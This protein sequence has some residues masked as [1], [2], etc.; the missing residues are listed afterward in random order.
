MP[1]G[2][3]GGR[4]E[5]VQ[6]SLKELLKLE[7]QR[8]EEQARERAAREAVAARERE[9]AERLRR[10]DVEAQAK[11]DAA[12]REH[13]RRTELEELARREAMQKAIVEQSRLE[14]EVRARADERERE[15]RHEIA[16]EQLRSTSK[17]GQS[18]GALMAASALGGG[19]MAIVGIVIH[20]GVL[21]PAA[22]RRLAGLEQGVAAAE[23]RADQL[24]RQ[25]DEE[26]RRGGERERQLA[27]AR[28]AL[29]ALT[30][31]SP[32]LPA[33]TK[34]GRTPPYKGATPKTVEKEKDNDCLD[35]D[36]MCFSLKTGR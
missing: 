4:D 30:S 20:L 19:V 1:S 26:R 11:A 2:P 35:G 33:T 36:P 24:G 6:F 12:A 8:L 21:R 3:T 31:K 23:G 27:D 15:R 29:Q 9:E 13:Q 14:V 16:I 17:R 5:S 7:D 34:L 25:L 32:P 10:V 28:N 18:L 22:E